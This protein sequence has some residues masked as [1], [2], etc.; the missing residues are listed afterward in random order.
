[1]FPGISDIRFSLYASQ[2]GAL[3]NKTV[4]FSVKCVLAIAVFLSVVVAAAA[5]VRAVS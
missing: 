1:M 4:Q 3:E 5:A 2:F